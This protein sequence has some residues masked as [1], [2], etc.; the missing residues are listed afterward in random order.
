MNLKRNI[1]YVGKHQECNFV[2]WS[3][4]NLGV[5]KVHETSCSIGK[6]IRGGFKQ[7]FLHL[8]LIFLSYRKKMK[9]FFL[10]FSVWHILFSLLC[11]RGVTVHVWIT[12]GNVKKQS[13]WSCTHEEGALKM[14]LCCLFFPRILWLFH[15][16][17]DFI[18][19]HLK[20]LTW[21]LKFLFTL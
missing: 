9:R 18:F 1:W 6:D 17:S 19:V 12:N 4:L 2:G 13:S 15:C 16:N 3:S 8:P 7:F 10:F 20:K 5:Q 21:L 14:F 11:I